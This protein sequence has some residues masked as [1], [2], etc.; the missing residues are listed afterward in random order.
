MSRQIPLDRPLSDEDREYLVSR[1]RDDLIA[2]LDQDFGDAEAPV[3]N[4]SNL[5]HQS[6]AAQSPA[7]AENGEQPQVPT[8][9]PQTG[10]SAEQADGSGD[11]GNAERANYDDPAA[12]SY[13]D[14][15]AEVKERKDDGAEDAPALNSPREVLVAWLFEDDAK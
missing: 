15:K 4:D 12:W 6:P 3:V 10:L 13:D 5:G 7:L 8:L 9:T 14:L 11:Q 1:G 2:R